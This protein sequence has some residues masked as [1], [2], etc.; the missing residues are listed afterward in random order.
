MEELQKDS[1]VDER[2]M[3]A[4]W[5]RQSGRGMTS[6]AATRPS[7]TPKGPAQV[8]AQTRREGTG[9]PRRIRDETSSIHGPED[10]PGTSQISSSCRRGREGTRGHAEG[11][12]ELLA[13]AAGGDKG[14]IGPAQAHAGS[15]TAG[16]ASSTSQHEPGQIFR[17]FDRT[18]RKHVESR[19][20]PTTRPTDSCNPG[21]E[22]KCPDLISD[23]VP[24]RRCSYG[25]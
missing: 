18:Y 13:S 22:G 21:V 24:R 7:S 3:I 6:G 9:T 20:R 14:P 19:G 8:L 17:S 25:G 10:G 11:P 4:P 12:G 15:P 23:P 2:G 5:P 16:N 1:Y